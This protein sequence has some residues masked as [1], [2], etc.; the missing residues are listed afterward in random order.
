MTTQQVRT[1]HATLKVLDLGTQVAGPF[2]AT[3]L[4]DLGAEVIKIEQP[5]RGDP[6]R[7][8]GMSARWQVEGRNKRSITLNLR[9]PEGQQLLT[10]LACWADVLIENFRPGTMSRWGVGPDELAA[11]NPRLV[12]V[13]VSGFGATG[14]YAQRSGYDHIGSAFGGLTA[15]TGYPDRAPVLPGLFLTDHITGLFAAVGALEAVRRRDAAGADGRGTAV[16]SALFESIVR[17]AGAD[18]ADYR[19]NGITRTRAGGAPTGPD[20][21]ESPLPYVYRTRDGR[22]LSVYPVTGSQLAQLR[23]IV[24]DPALDDPRFDDNDGRARNA[25]DW[26]EILAAWIGARD[27]S[28]LWEMLG[29]TDVPA[30][31]VNTVPDLLGDPHVIERRSLVEIGNDEGELITM[32]GVVPRIGPVPDEIRWTGQRLGASNRDVYRGLL[33]LTADELEVLRERGVV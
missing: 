19:L 21:F 3:I 16:D 31:A 6:I 30:S 13:G 27:Y 1:D 25:S 15:V 22:W 12:Y 14:P 7:L 5:E 10:R 23:R 26:H 32:P 24:R 8:D 11:V 29:D 20:A 4:G 2:A 9:V 33:G 28:E 18:I 17:I